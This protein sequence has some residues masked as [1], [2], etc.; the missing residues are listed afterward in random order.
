MKNN[1]YL[2]ISEDKSIRDF[3]LHQILEKITY[4]EDDKITI[5]LSVNSITDLLDEAAMLSMFS[6][7]KVIIANNFNPDKITE[8]ELTYFEKYLKN[9]NPN[10]Y[11]ILLTTKVDTRKKC[12]KLLKEYFTIYEESSFNSNNVSEYVK[13]ILKE[14][15]YQMPDLDL[16][17]QRV[18]TDLNNINSELNKLMLY[19][20]KSKVI[21]YEDITLLI[22]DNIETIMYEFTNAFFDKNY[23]KLTTMYQQFKKDN[24][25]SDYLISSLAGSIRNN[26]IIKYLKSCGKSNFDISKIINK[27][28]F[29]VKK[30]LERLYYYSLDDLI[31]LQ[32]KLA[33][34][35]YR[36]KSGQSNIDELEFFLLN[37]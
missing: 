4:Q 33:N 28:E 20:E 31:D 35:D 23:E 7:T 5:D 10:N 9:P 3:N 1:L 36:L 21:T 19:K 14:H 12:Y 13:K 18:G 32:L 22:Q 24:I 11:I 25:S 27:K 16:F 34:I 29:F 15:K 8:Y 6:D 17:L 2:I 37:K 30:S 26:I